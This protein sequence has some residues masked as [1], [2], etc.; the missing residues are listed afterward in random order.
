MSAENPYSSATYY[1]VYGDDLIFSAYSDGHGTELW[2]S[3]GTAS[4]TWMIDDLRQGTSSSAPT[5]LEVHDN[6]VYFRA[7][8]SFE[9]MEL[10]R[11]HRL[12][13][14]SQDTASFASDEYGR[15]ELWQ[16]DG[17]AQGTVVL[18][19][20][21]PSYGSTTSLLQAPAC[22]S[23]PMT[24]HTREL[25]VSETS[26]GTS[27][28]ADLIS[29]RLDSSFPGHGSNSVSKKPVVR[30]SQSAINT[31]SLRSIPQIAQLMYTG[32]M[33]GNRHLVV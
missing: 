24:Q 21:N 20:I 18:K 25:W 1:V 4:G 29:I 23:R 9:Q 13:P 8:M 12:L 26:M 11:E 16:S 33:E 3:D 32:S 31:T 2:R 28:V 14:T 5:Y 30:L 6:H 7:T 19:T 10:L 17:T 15:Q 22:F 27:M